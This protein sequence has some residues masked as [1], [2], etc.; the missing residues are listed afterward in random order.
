MKKFILALMMVALLATS[1]MAQEM[2]LFIWSEYMPDDFVPEFEKQTGIDVRVDYYESM[3]EMLAKLQAG[4][5]SQYDVIVPSD[6]IISSLVNLGLLKELDHSRIPNM[7]NLSEMFVSPPYDPGNK[8]TVAYQWGTLGMLYNGDVI[9]SDQPSWGVMFNPEQQVGPFV[10]IDSVRE[11]LGCA[12]SYMGMDVNTTEKSKLKQLAKLMLDTKKSKYFQGFDVGTGGRSK[13]VAKTAVAAIVYN[14]DGLRAVKE[15]PGIKFANPAEGTVAWVDNMAICKDAPNPDAAYKFINYVLDAKTGA[16]LSN[17]TEY[18][19][20]NEAA[21]EFINPV[22]LNNPSVYPPKEY[23]SKLHFIND[24]GKN[25]RIYD[26]L[27]TMIK[28]R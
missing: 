4:G 17:W 20:P 19:S 23:M 22:S 27:W 15:N 13:V 24:L 11:M 18:A 26:E 21:H 5:V 25:N 12:Q 3:E 9:K 28:T 7:K 16:K 6:Y 2:R 1:A 14:G 8:Y 10:L